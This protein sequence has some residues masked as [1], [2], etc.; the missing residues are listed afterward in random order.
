MNG[1][2]TSFEDL[3]KEAY[4]IQEFTEIQINEDVSVA[5]ERGNML[6]IYISRTGKMLADA[7]YHLNDARKSEAIQL[8]K[9]ITSSKYSARLQN[10]LVE[11]IA[12]EQQYM[13]DWIER[14]NRT[15]THQMEWCRTLVSKAKEEMRLNGVSREFGNNY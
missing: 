15:C 14:L 13:V 12:K 7:K 11:S 1:L 6:V 10:T 4:D 3:Q 5:V 8:I 9:Q 2:I